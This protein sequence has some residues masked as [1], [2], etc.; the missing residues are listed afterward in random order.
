MQGRES[1]RGANHFEAIR[2]IRAGIGGKAALTSLL[3]DDFCTSLLG[4]LA[5]RLDSFLIARTARVCIVGRYREKDL[6]VKTPYV[7]GV[8]N[9]PKKLA[10]GG[11]R[12]RRAMSR[13]SPAF[14]GLQHG[15]SARGRHAEL[16]ENA[17]FFI[18][19]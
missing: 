14:V 2:S 4:S 18:V 6:S 10:R 17:G 13:A 3:T 16:S 15:V 19:L 11:A 1:A 12:P 5:H 9:K 8:F 7:A